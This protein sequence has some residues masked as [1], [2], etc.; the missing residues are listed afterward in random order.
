MNINLVKPNKENLNTF[1]LIG[2]VLI[3]L[4]FFDFLANTFLDLD[5]T[6]LNLYYKNRHIH[7]IIHNNAQHKTMKSI[8]HLFLNCH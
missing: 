2:S 1:V 3:L 6:K 7:N 4:G 8:I 5:F